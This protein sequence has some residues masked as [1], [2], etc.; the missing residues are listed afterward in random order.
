MVNEALQANHKIS[1]SY[2]EQNDS[3]ICSVTGKPD[4]CD[5]AKKCF[6]SHA[7]SYTQA[8]WVAMFKYHVIWNKG[9]WED[10]EP[11]EDFG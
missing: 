5:N 2:S 7:K 1:F 3:Y 11:E 8:L 6:T 9:V 10:V 4:E